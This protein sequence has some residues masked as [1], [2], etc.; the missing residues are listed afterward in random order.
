MIV[1]KTQIHTGTVLSVL[2][3]DSVKV[4]IPLGRVHKKDQDLGFHMHIENNRI[5]LHTVIRLR[6]CNA[7][8]LHSFGGVEAKE[9][10]FGLLPVGTLVTLRTVAADKYGSRWD[11]DVRLADGTDLVPHLISTGWAAAWDGTGEKPIPVWPRVQ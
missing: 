6:R 4:S 3:G 1:D 7:I 9:N 11:A 10:L 2:D 8:E 5:C